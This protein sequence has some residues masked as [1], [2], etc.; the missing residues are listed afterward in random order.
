MFT[1]LRVLEALT[2]KYTFPSPALKPTC[3][4]YM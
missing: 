2:A 1:M 4:T 3:L